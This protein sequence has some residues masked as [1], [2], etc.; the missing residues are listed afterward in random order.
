[1]EHTV[2]QSKALENHIIILFFNEDAIFFAAKES[3]EPKQTY[4]CLSIILIILC[5]MAFTLGPETD[6][7][8]YLFI[9]AS[10]VLAI[11]IGLMIF[12]IRQCVITRM[13]R[14]DSSQS[15]SYYAYDTSDN[16]SRRMIMMIIMMNRRI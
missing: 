15:Y 1:M 3:Q 6:G 7:D 8:T 13:N 11:A 5:I 14:I 10:I 2:Q 4:V 12:S 9:A 16:K